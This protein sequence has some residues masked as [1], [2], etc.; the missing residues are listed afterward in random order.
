[1]KGLCWGAQPSR[2]SAHPPSARAWY[3][4]VMIK[5]AWFMAMRSAVNWQEK[6]YLRWVCGG[7][8][9]VRVGEGVGEGQQA[10]AR[11]CTHAPA[12][13]PAHLGS[14]ACQLMSASSY[15]RPRGWQ[16]QRAGRQY[17]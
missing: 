3:V 7:G 9:G 17:L 6:W 11:G 4:L 2:A 15:L 16:G 14:S 5:S 10:Q 12:P 8:G 1:M 13:R